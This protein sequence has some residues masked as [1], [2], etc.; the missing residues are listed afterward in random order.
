MIQNIK[1]LKTKRS[2]SNVS[3]RATIAAAMVGLL[4]TACAS[5]PP[6]NQQ[7]TAAE[8][9]IDHA[10]KAQVPDYSSLELVEARANLTAARAAI[11]AKDMEKARHL[12][13]RAQLNADLAEAKANLSKA[14]AV[15]EELQKNTSVIKEEMQR[16][17]GVK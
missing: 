7:I 11:E 12:A 6:P 13:Q 15:N 14:K 3:L 10:E 4:F 16:N 2:V 17:P 5:T 1:Q 9:A 8:V